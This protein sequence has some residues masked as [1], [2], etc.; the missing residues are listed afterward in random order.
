MPGLF[1]DYKNGDK[2]QF[3]NSKGEFA[4]GVIAGLAS[5]DIV[6]IFIVTLDVPA[7]WNCACVQY[8]QLAPLVSGVEALAQAA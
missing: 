5:K 2:V 4:T 6:D 1:N 8:D 3:T 7:E